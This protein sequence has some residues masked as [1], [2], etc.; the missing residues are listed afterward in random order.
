[1]QRP[2]S[3]LTAVIHSLCANLAQDPAGREYAVARSLLWSTVQMVSVAL[4]AVAMCF[5]PTK[6]AHSLSLSVCLSLCLP[7]I[8]INAN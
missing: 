8:T 7:T 5:W 3:E 2:W 4:T 1:M 6:P